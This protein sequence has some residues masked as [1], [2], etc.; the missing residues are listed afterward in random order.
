MSI[1]GLVIMNVIYFFHIRSD[2]NAWCTRCGSL[3]SIIAT[4]TL[5]IV[6]M[7]SIFK[8]GANTCTAQRCIK[9]WFS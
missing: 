3:M 5:Y 8:A 9:L 2:I 1:F 4:C 7:Y 6:R